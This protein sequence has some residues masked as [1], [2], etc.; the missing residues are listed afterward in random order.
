MYIQ[1]ERDRYR[2]NKE[3]TCRL[4]ID[5]SQSIQ[6]YPHWN[7]G[8]KCATRTTNFIAINRHIST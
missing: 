8:D 3:A 2:G 5:D 7:I 1:E 4:V 6:R